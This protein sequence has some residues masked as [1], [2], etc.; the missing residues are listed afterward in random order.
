MTKVLHLPKDPHPVYGEM[1]H[2][3]NRS[4]P[5][6]TRMPAPYELSVANAI[7]AQVAFPWKKE[8]AELTRTHYGTGLEEVDFGQPEP[9]R[10]RINAWVEDRTRDRIKELIPSG[11]ITPLTRMV[12]A[13][14]VYFKGQW[15]EAHDPRRT[16]PAPFTRA[17]GTTAEVPMMQRRGGFRMHKEA[18]PDGSAG[19]QELSLAE[20]PYKGGQVSMVVLVPG[21]P[22]GLPA[23]EKKLTPDRLAEWLA[24]AKDHETAELYLPRFRVE[25]RY[26]L[27]RPLQALGIREAFDP[28][29][30]DFFGMHTSRERLFVNFVVQ[31]TFVDVNEEGTEAAAATAVGLMKKSAPPSV[32]ANRPFLFLI[33]HVP[34]GTILFIGRYAGP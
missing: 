34:T 4:G 24:A 18:R 28:R 23:L 15:A 5:F 1:L 25:A 31:K 3:L 14:A 32:V 12:L 16:H 30:A 33:R 6:A 7:W 21:K 19:E 20:V 9:A 10:K 27:K 8:F 11:H 2:R 13:N 26:D 17:N 29:R 22:D